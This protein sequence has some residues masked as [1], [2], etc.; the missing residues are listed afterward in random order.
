MGPGIVAFVP[1]TSLLPFIFELG[2]VRNSNMKPVNILL[3][4]L[5][6]TTGLRAQD[7]TPKSDDAAPGVVSVEPAKLA[8]ARE[9]IAATQADKMLDGIAAQMKQ[10]AAQMTRLPPN[11]TAEQKQQITE[12]QEQTMDMLM[13]SVKKLLPRMDRVFAES[14]TEAELRAILAFY[15]SPEGRSMLAKQPQILARLMP[16]IQE[17]NREL[18]ARI[19]S[20]VADKKAALAAKASAEA[21][22]ALEGAAPVEK[23][24]S[25]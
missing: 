17:M 12:F 4:L 13:E 11:A 10:V 6:L 16:E 9:V 8:L 2:P 7:N 21:K 1:R 14:Y 25:P 24:A 15:T 22:A 5:V 18:M 3:A 23:P 20:L 19:R